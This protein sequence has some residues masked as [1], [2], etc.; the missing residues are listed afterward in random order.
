M[1]YSAKT[2]APVFATAV[3]VDSLKPNA[4]KKETPKYNTLQ[5]NGGA[6]DA[7]VVERLM[8]QGFSRG[9]AQ[10]L[11]KNT[12]TFPYRIWVVDNS[13]SMLKADGNRIIETRSTNLVKIVPC[14]RWDEI[15]ECVNYHIRMAGLLEVTTSFRLLN[16][17]GA[18]VGAQHFDIAS[19]PG[20]AP[21]E[22]QRA[23]TIMNQTRPGGCTPLTQHIMDIYASV[24]DMAPDLRSSGKKVVIVLATDGLPTDEL[25]H[26]GPSQQQQ[27]V[28]TL[29]LLEGLPVWV[30]IRLCTDD[31]DV[32][33]FYNDLDEQLELSLEVLDDFCAEALEVYEHNKWL[34]Y[35]LPLHRCREMGYHDRVFD[36]IDERPLTKGELRDFFTIL[37]GD[38]DGVPDPAVNWKGFMEEISNLLQREQKQ[39]NPVKKKVLPWIDLKKL[40]KTYGEGNCSIM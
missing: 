22:M 19:A 27:F 5:H 12:A 20:T 36:L 3:S 21:L 30:V 40:N 37:F 9:L 6:L 1:S 33:N 25:G 38:I 14:S 4:T 34:N 16:H 13:G 18:T 2:S 26:G 24:F 35:A 7:K 32:V 39:W 8:N 28:E 17:P 11:A 10:S 29:R 31:D 23:M 15:R